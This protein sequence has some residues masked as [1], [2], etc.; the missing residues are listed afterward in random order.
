MYTVV[1]V[2]FTGAGSVSFN[3]TL[4]TSPEPGSLIVLA[5]GLPMLGL[6]WLRR[7]K[8]RIQNG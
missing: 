5:T 8:A 7:R 4:G 1:T 2:T 6:G 3:S